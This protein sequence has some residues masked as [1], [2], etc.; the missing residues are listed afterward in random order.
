MEAAHRQETAQLRQMLEA[1][2]KVIAQLE[3]TIQLLRED[4]ERLRSILNNDSNNS[5]Q[6]PSADQKGKRTN[7]YNGRVKNERSKGAQPGHRGTTLTRKDVEECI[8]AGKLQRKIVD[9]GQ[10]PGKAVVKYVVDLSVTSH[11][12]SIGSIRT[13]R[14]S[15]AFRWNYTVM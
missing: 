8:A 9:H 7:T 15:T 5:S 13:A 12:T 6:P 14:A 1:Q 3:K 4:N 11:V 10:G 2:G